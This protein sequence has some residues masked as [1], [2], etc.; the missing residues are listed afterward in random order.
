MVDGDHSAQDEGGLGRV[1]IGLLFPEY[2]VSKRS[3]RGV[4]RTVGKG[5]KL[6]SADF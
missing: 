1:N 6:F 3:G 2:S 5:G 4:T